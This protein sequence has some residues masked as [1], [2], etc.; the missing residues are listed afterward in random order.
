M[1][2][3]ATNDYNISFDDYRFRWC[4][5]ES[6]H[7]LTVSEEKCPSTILPFENFHSTQAA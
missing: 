5:E 6:I 2:T 4:Y 1:R 7:R 3:T